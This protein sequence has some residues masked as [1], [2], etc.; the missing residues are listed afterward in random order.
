M[1][2]D[3]SEDSEVAEERKRISIGMGRSDT[4]VLSSLYKQYGAFVAVDRI[5]VGVPEQECFGL[6]GQN[7]AGKTTTFKMLTGDV[8]VTA[9]NAFVGQHSI[10]T[11]I[12]QVG[13]ILQADVTCD[14]SFPLT[15]ADVTCDWS[16]SLTHCFSAFFSFVL[17]KW[18]FCWW[19]VFVVLRLLFLLASC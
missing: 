2:G 9:G 14:W 11:D 10:K 3:T 16:F 6:L 7:G 1:D 15:Q 8:M 18:M 13:G 4:L 19:K 17:W 12:K 5:S